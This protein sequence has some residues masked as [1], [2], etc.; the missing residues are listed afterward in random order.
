MEDLLPDSLSPKPESDQHLMVDEDTIT[1]LVDAASLVKTDIVLEIGGGIGTLT[2][3]I[4]RRAGKVV[5]FEKDVRYYNSLLERF[6]NNPSVSV[7][8][9]DI[10][11][12]R[13]PEFNKLV[14]N[15]P[16]SIIKQIFL[17]LAREKRSGLDLAVMTLPYRFTME[18]TA[19]VDSSYF[20]PVSVLSLAFFDITIISSVDRSKF[21]PPPRV[22]SFCVKIVTKP[23]QKGKKGM[24]QLMMQGLFLYERKKASKIF[25]DA[26]WNYGYSVLGHKVS[27]REAAAIVTGIFP[28]LGLFGENTTSNLSRKE[29]ASIV[30]SLDRWASNEG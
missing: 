28:E 19:G 16:Y 15:P 6:A 2:K 26:I 1:M 7:I 22:T 8:N 21:N 11:T 17:K 12:A 25:R 5:V 14:S 9:G 3:E 30:I 20:N 29:F 13:L 10:L 24:A 18:L 23:L 4:V 27:K